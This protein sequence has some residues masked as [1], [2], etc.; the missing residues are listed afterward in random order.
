[1]AIDNA[2]QASRRVLE[3]L[4]DSAP[5]RELTDPERGR[6]TLREK[7]QTRLADLRWDRDIPDGTCHLYDPHAGRHKGACPNPA[8]W[9]GK[10][11]GVCRSH[12]A[13]LT[14]EGVDVLDIKTLPRKAS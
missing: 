12:Q 3:H 14:R 6:E 13:L 8:P 2:L 4:V 10:H 9:T 7:V 11:T 1:M 5:P